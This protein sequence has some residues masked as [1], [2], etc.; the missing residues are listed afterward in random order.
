MPVIKTVR[1]HSPVIPDNCFIAENA[2][3]VGEVTMGSQCSVW[4]SAVVRG[5]VNFI[6]MGNKVNIQ[7]GAVIHGTYQK[8]GT[9]IGNNVSVGH[10]ALVHGCTIHDNVLVGMGSIIMDGCVIESNSIVAA[11]AVITQNTVV[12]SGSI[13]AGVP[14][15]KVKNVSEAHVLGEINR[16]ADAYI[17]YSSWFKE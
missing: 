3:I 4:F 16:I 10:N 15:K 7:D 8:A 9:T 2:T 17:K 5:D 1:G 12:E 13:Y 11:G 14:A 6:K